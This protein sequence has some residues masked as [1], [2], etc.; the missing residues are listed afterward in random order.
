MSSDCVKSIPGRACCREIYNQI[1]APAYTYGEAW[2]VRTLDKRGN[3]VLPYQL[4]TMYII[5]LV[6]KRAIA[7]ARIQQPKRGAS[8]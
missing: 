1:V 3:T 6:Y 4:H 2:P 7:E 5:R 8:G